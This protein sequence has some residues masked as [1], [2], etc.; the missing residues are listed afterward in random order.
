MDRSNR[1]QSETVNIATNVQPSVVLKRIE[2]STTSRAEHYHPDPGD[3]PAVN[4]DPGEADVTV[5]VAD[6]PSMS[7]PSCSYVCA[8]LYCRWSY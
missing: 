1:D 8:V 5:T 7:G 6:K 3:Q 2:I 4:P